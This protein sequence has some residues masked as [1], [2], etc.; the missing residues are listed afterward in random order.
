M[1]TL[2]EQP[3]MIWSPTENKWISTYLYFTD[4]PATTTNILDI[5]N[6]YTPPA[7]TVSTTPNA[8]SPNFSPTSGY[9]VLLPLG[10]FF[11]TTEIWYTD[12]SKTAKIVEKDITW[13]GIVPTTIVYKLYA[14]DG[15]TIAQEIQDVISYTKK[16][17]VASVART[18]LV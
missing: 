18:V 2:N 8:F 4:Q 10:S 16:I 7:S 17:I 3:I 15:I 9:Q 13:S 14:A 12:S 5:D 1:T 11:P 6:G